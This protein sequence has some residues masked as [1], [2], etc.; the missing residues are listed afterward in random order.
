MWQTSTWYRNSSF[1]L[2]VSEFGKVL[3]SGTA[4]FA[5]LLTCWL[6]FT[7][8]QSQQLVLRNKTDSI[9]FQRRHHPDL[10]FFM[11]IYFLPNT[12]VWMY[13]SLFLSYLL[14]RR[15][16]HHKLNPMLSFLPGMQNISHP[17][18]TKSQRNQTSI[19]IIFFYNTEHYFH[20]DVSI[21]SGINLKA[22]WGHFI[23]KTQC[24][25]WS[26]QHKAL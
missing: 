17:Y 7:H 8:T 22:N 24:F 26:L 23:T 20:T 10:L 13:F 11:C 3:A 16:F 25:L 9:Y 6:V 15:L 12:N 21:F 4:H 14:A 1:L 2:S 19:Y 18:I 5:Y